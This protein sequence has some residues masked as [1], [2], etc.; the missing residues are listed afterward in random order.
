MAAADPL[1][2][3]EALIHLGES[4][5]GLLTLL[6][7]SSLRGYVAMLVLPVTNDQVLQGV[8]RNGLAL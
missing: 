4:V 3:T 2:G 5:K 6:A 8:V 7:L 1:G